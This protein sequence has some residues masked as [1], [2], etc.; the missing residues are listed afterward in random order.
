MLLVI[1]G[2]RPDHIFSAGRCVHLRLAE[3]VINLL[4]FEGNGYWH[5]GSARGL[6]VSLGGTDLKAVSQSGKT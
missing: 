5:I 6:S 1:L 2:S 4:E 3:L